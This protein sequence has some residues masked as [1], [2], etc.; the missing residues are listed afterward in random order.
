MIEPSRSLASFEDLS[1]RVVHALCW[2]REWSRTSQ[3]RT[4]SDRPGGFHVM[5]NACRPSASAVLGAAVGQSW[6]SSATATNSAQPRLTIPSFRR[7]EPRARR[8]RCRGSAV[9]S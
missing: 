1:A 3:S 7:A 8:Y 4:L 6:P 5:A 2:A 9:N